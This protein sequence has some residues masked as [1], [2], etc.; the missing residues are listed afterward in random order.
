[1]QANLA[2]SEL[3]PPPHT[4]H[5]SLQLR[6]C[7]LLGINGCPDLEAQRQR[8]LGN[9][10]QCAWALDMAEVFQQLPRDEIQR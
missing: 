6:G 3:S 1:M 8:F 4:D 7:S 9:G 5:S 2:V 10:W